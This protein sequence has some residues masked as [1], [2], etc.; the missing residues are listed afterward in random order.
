MATGR[1]LEIEISLP[2]GDKVLAGPDGA[3]W[4]GG[5]PPPG[6]LPLIYIS[7]EAAGLVHTHAQSTLRLE[8]GGLLIGE[9]GYTADQRPIAIVRGAIAVDGKDSSGTHFVFGGHQQKAAY[10]ELDRRYP[11][12]QIVGWYHTHPRMSVFLSGTDLN[13]H[14]SLFAIPWQVALVLEPESNQ[15]GFFGWTGGAIHPVESYAAFVAAGDQPSLPWKA[16]GVGLSAAHPSLRRQPAPRTPA[17]EAPAAAPP[18]AVPPK[19]TNGQRATIAALAGAALL[20]FG[21]GF[22]VRGGDDDSKAGV[23][24]SPTSEATATA[25]RVTSTSATTPPTV[26]TT[27]GTTGPTPKAS[28]SVATSPVAGI[29]STPA[30]AKVEDDGLVLTVPGSA[31]DVTE[32]AA[33]DVLGGDGVRRLDQVLM[34]TEGQKVTFLFP[35]TLKVDFAAMT[36]KDA[37]RSHTIESSPVG[38]PEL[39]RVGPVFMASDTNGVHFF[40]P[41]ETADPNIFFTDCRRWLTYDSPHKDKTD[42]RVDTQD[43]S[44]RCSKPG[45]AQ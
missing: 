4:T 44:P 12:S 17:D 24:S 8:L 28:P 32:I 3:Q 34:I 5:S 18:A 37:L 33:V 43:P 26:L 11:R 36:L 38:L 29:A 1:D 42:S 10:E 9:A 41:F 27:P 2:A 31:L 14:R 23:E 13:S 30:G 35:R 45:N 6:D 15:A 16:A 39:S 7:D 19:R 21:A 22:L 20:G 40:I 25:A